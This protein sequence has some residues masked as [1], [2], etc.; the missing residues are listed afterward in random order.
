MFGQARSGRNILFRTKDPKPVRS[1]YSANIQCINIDWGFNEGTFKKI[2][3]KFFL[4]EFCFSKPK[5][6]KNRFFLLTRISQ[7][8][9]KYDILLFLLVFAINLYHK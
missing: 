4:I 6:N 5:P 7:L 1:H 2:Y 9:F 8:P 3:V